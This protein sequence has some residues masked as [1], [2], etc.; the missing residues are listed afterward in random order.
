MRGKL[1]PLEG[2]VGD[3]RTE[4]RLGTGRVRQLPMDAQSEILRTWSIV[5]Q[6]GEE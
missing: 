3:V 1:N 2:R 6:T 5:Y 4:R